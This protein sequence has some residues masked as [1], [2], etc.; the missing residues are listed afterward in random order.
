M[1]PYVLSAQRTFNEAKVGYGSGVGVRTKLRH[2][3]A[4]LVQLFWA[5]V[6][7]VGEAEVNEAPFSEQVLVREWLS[8]MG[9]HF[10]W[11]TDVR[12]SDGARFCLLLWLRAVYK[13]LN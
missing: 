7:A 12:A 10:K 9:R 2:G 5:Y 13:D 1:G 11:S 4:H 6:R 8:V 3:G